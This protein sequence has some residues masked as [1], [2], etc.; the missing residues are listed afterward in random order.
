ML[1]FSKDGFDQYPE[2]FSFKT[3]AFILRPEGYEDE[4]GKKAKAPTLMTV[5]G[6]VV[7]Y[8]EVQIHTL[9]AFLTF[10]AE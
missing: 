3:R 9:Q 7:P 10:F 8:G 1:A 4:A 5:D 6:E 2:S